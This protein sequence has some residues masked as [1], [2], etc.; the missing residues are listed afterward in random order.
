MVPGKKR[1]GS[2]VRNGT[3][4]VDVRVGETDGGSTG[5]PQAGQNRLPSGTVREQ[6]VHVIAAPPRRDPRRPSGWRGGAY[7]RRHP[8]RT[9]CRAVSD[10]WRVTTPPALE[11]DAR[12]RRVTSFAFLALTS[13]PAEGTCA[14]RRPPCRNSPPRPSPPTSSARIRARYPR[15]IQEGPAA[16]SQIHR[17]SSRF[18]HCLKWG[19]LSQMP[20]R[21]MAS[22]TVLPATTLWNSGITALILFDG[23]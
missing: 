2:L 1:T 11:A 18:S 10:C 16:I 5:T 14:A 12:G 6:D 9:T 23:G 19:H 8:G 4:G 3:S 15:P 21:P 7:T 17:L 13:S 22:A 20:C